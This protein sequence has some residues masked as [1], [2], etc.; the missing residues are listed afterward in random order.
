[1]MSTYSHKIIILTF[2][3]FSG[4]CLAYFMLF[5]GHPV[6]DV[7][8][9]S[10]G[11]VAMK[12][13]D[14]PILLVW[15]WPFGIQIDPADCETYFNI[16]N[17]VL[18]GDRSLYNVSDAIIFSH[19]SIQ[20]NLANMPHAPRPDFQK[21]IWYHVESPR[22][23]VRRAGFGG[24]FNLTLTYRRDADITVRNEVS[25]ARTAEE[26]V[27]PRKD[28]MVCWIVSNMS[29][30]T[31]TATRTAY[32]QNL[33]KYINVEMYGGASKR[34]LSPDEYYPTI[35]SCKFY[36]AFENSLYQDY[37]TEKVNGPLV[38][39]TVPVVMGPPRENYEQFFPADSFIH[40]DDFSDPK[41]LAEYLLQLVLNDDM[42][43]QYFRWRKYF[44]ATPHLTKREQEFLQPLCE[45]CEHIGTDN[46]FS[47]VNNL[48]EWQFG[49]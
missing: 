10:P 6:S 37:I 42:Y 14:K 39:G 23:T 29:H 27:V 16:N 40:V 12:D 20:W 18:T 47:V 5:S 15:F 44:K 38:A 11:P 41:A 25:I 46:S 33:T 7:E 13:L 26:F 48:N 43:K 19:K 49:L 1:M 32:V 34:P 28:K 17:C 9:Q 22:N 30:R 2:L 45:A 21:W 24:L 35:A 3:A 36:L 31:G 4:L 8:D